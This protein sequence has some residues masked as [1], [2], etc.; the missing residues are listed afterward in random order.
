MLDTAEN[1][2]N[3][4]GVESSKQNFTD[5]NPTIGLTQSEV[6]RRKKLGMANILPPRS[7]RTNWQIVRD[8]VFTRVNLLLGVLFVFVLSTGSWVNG[9]FGLLIFF[10]SIIGIVQEMRA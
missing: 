1:D 8:N 7:G 3:D 4:E 6:E 10:N 5:T 2:K 9:A